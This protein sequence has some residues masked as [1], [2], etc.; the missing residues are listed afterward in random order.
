MI[1]AT[2]GEDPDKKTVRQRKHHRNLDVICQLEH[3]WQQAKSAVAQ[4]GRKK[5]EKN[6]DDRSGIRW[7]KIGQKNQQNL[8][9]QVLHH[10]AAM[11]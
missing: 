1:K 4:M 6:R 2:G 5:K 10:S 8:K 7:E 3:V 9:N 11:Q